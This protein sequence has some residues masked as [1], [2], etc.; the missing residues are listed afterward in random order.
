MKKLFFVAFA[1]VLGFMSASAQYFNTTKGAE[2]IYRSVN[3]ED[4]A[5]KALKATII[6]VTTA[7]DGVITAR[8]EDLQSDPANPL[9]EIKTFRSYSY[10]PATGV[11]KVVVMTAD[12]F[13]DFVMSMI[14]QGMQAAGQHMSEM[15]FADLANN[16]SAKGSLEY[17]IDPKAAP[18]TKLP[19]STLRLNAG[20]MTMNANLWNGK[21]VGQESVTV[22]AGTYDCIKVSYSMVMS[23]PNGNNKQNITDWFAPG[24]GIVKSVETDK[25]GN[26]I[27]ED[28]LL[29][30]K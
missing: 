30:I 13:K 23:G 4:K 10:N 20:M 11:T 26:V 3:L 28:V 8:E 12:D 21:I 16:I 7:A 27:S 9:I 29:G 19:K 17:E 24:V 6:D 22:P 2:L 18:D 5:E 14:R 25:K 1:T 15:E